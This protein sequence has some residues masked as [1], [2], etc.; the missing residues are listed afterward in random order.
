MH[1]VA[2]NSTRPRLEAWDHAWKYDT[3][4]VW[5]ALLPNCSTLC[6][7]CNRLYREQIDILASNNRINTMKKKR[8]SSSYPGSF[9]SFNSQG[10][11][12]AETRLLCTFPPKQQLRL[13]LS[14][15]S[16]QYSTHQYDDPCSWPHCA[17][18]LC[19]SSAPPWVS[20]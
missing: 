18:A 2:N 19:S 10:K 13:Q 9:A 14:H 12:T 5:P 17:L 4:V 1:V 15:S 16:P 3:P 11:S 20:S 8:R 7:A 6:S